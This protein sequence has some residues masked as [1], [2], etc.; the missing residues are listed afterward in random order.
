MGVVF[1]VVKA[2]R[3]PFDLRALTASPGSNCRKPG[4]DEDSVSSRQA[5]SAALEA[6][7]ATSLTRSS[8]CSSSR[9]SDAVGDGSGSSPAEPERPTS[10]PFADSP[11]N[12]PNF[13][14]TDARGPE[15]ESEAGSLLFLRRKVFAELDEAEDALGRGEFHPQG[16]F[17]CVCKGEAG[18]AAACEEESLV[19]EFMSIRYYLRR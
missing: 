6:G 5:T 15:K 4:L 8:S 11:W 14:E 19:F 1:R 16:A 13:A 7:G 18:G 2:Q 10:P 12:R 17:C 9:S 3:V